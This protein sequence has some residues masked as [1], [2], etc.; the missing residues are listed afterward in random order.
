MSSAE[1]AECRA[2]YVKTID[3]FTAYTTSRLYKPGSVD[4]RILLATIDRA[5]ELW[6]NA[7]NDKTRMRATTTTRT[8]HAIGQVKDYDT[9]TKTNRQTDRGSIPNRCALCGSKVQPEPGEE[10]AHMQ[11]KH[12]T[13]A[14]ST[15]KMPSNITLGYY[16][17]P[18]RGHNEN[19]E[20]YSPRKWTPLEQPVQPKE[21]SD[22][23][24]SISPLTP[25]N[26]HHN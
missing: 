8:R 12:W 1:I 17:K 20:A 18:K 24:G 11:T 13:D 26:H 2:I 5:H 25:P 22:S 3:N 21:T 9:R 23:P 14:A 16:I 7:R 10:K 15:L 19:K 4:E 6:F